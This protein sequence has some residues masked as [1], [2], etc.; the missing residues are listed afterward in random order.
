MKQH[1]I[2]ARIVFAL[3]FT[4]VIIGFTAF[5]QKQQKSDTDS[6]RKK[7]FS[8]DGDTTA[9]GKHNRDE[10]DRKFD[11]L[12]NQL[13]QLDFQL[14]NLELQIKNF[15][16][17]KLQNEIDEAAKKV[18]VE[19]ITERLNKSLQNIDWDK[20]N[21][22][23]VENLKVSKLRI[24]E[25]AKEMEHVKVN[26]EKQKNNL[27]LNTIKIG[28][29]VKNAMKNAKR[30]IENAKDELR[31]MKEFTDELEKDGLIDKSKA[32]KIEVKNGEL[33]IDDKKQTKEIFD[34]YRRYYRKSNFKINMSEGYEYRI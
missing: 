16:L 23:I 15:D 9:A 30:S 18:D 12:D 5:S 28:A 19:K 3:A 8:Q 13:K 7:Q 2:F 10:F 4:V 33:Y 29:N 11:R 17:E 24:A 34:K 25:A 20:I 27:K 6:F 32:Y 26:L 31:N 1:A 14:K 21:N 22:R